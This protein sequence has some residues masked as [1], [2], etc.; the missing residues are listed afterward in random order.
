MPAV[1][2]AQRQVAFHRN[3]WSVWIGIAGRLRSDSPVGMHR[4]THFDYQTCHHSSWRTDQDPPIIT[5]IHS[6]LSHRAAKK[7]YQSRYGQLGAK[8]Q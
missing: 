7:A 1:N 4:I 3:R 6:R 5:E 8:S 2:P